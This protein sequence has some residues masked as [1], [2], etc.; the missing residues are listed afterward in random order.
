MRDAARGPEEEGGIVHLVGAGPGD[1]G[2]L[3]VRGLSLL[4]RADAVVHDRLVDLSLLD[5]APE[6][7]ERIDVGKAPG[8]HTV[9][10]RE[11]NEQLVA[12]AQRGLRVVRLKGGDP[13][14]FGRGGEECEALAAAGILFEVVP[15]VSSALAVPAVAGIPLTH[16][17]LAGSFTVVTGHRACAGEDDPGA[18]DWELLVRSETLVVLMGVQH[19]PRIARKL[20]EHG[21]PAETP[22]AAIHAGTT[23]SQ[24]LVSGSLADFVDPE[25]PASRLRSPATIVIGPVA[26]LAQTLAPLASPSAID[27]STFAVPATIHEPD[28]DPGAAIADPYGV[29]PWENRQ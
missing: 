9:S 10:Q 29:P 11:I 28:D 27:L 23:P 4:R 16:R 12:L 15:G 18:L 14:V 17:G 26:A 22:L 5:E 13:F 24:T 6:E 7:A 20:L 1:P 8:R 2:L 21:R 19:L 3:T 25:G